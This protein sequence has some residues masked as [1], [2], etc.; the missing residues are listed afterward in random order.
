MAFRMAPRT[1]LYITV[2]EIQA[3]KTNQDSKKWKK[4]DPPPKKNKEKKGKLKKK[5][6][7]KIEIF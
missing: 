6:N 4:F 5:K 1:S 7:K 3:K 2:H